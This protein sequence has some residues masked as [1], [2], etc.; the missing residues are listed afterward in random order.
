MNANCIKRSQA[1]FNR[2]NH[3]KLK[4][5]MNRTGVTESPS[6]DLDAKKV[7]TTINPRKG[8]AS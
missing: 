3:I 4:I 8:T 1:F 7:R 6:A 5:N 2:K